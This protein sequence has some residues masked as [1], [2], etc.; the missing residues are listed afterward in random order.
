MTAVEK[1]QR[2]LS[3]VLIVV[4]IVIVGGVI[5]QFLVMDNSSNYNQPQDKNTGP[6][7]V[8][9]ASTIFVD[10]PVSIQAMQLQDGV[11]YGIFLN[12]ELFFNFTAEGQ[13]WVF[14]SSYAIEECVSE[15]GALYVEFYL[16]EWQPLKIWD[17]L[18]INIE[19]VN[20]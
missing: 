6:H 1:D 9:A 4:A 7:L 10:T 18:R 14:T 13:N 15:D 12:Q 16:I 17:H 8:A 2:L 19:E 11:D 20:G 3:A 5:I